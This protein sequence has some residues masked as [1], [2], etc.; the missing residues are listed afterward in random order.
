VSS[1]KNRIR[2]RMKITMHVTFQLV[3]TSSLQ[4]NYCIWLL[5]SLRMCDWWNVEGCIR[6]RQ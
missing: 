3:N 4:Q 5:R 2:I 1:L 6:K